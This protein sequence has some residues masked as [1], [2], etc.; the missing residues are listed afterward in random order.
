[1][2]LDDAINNRASVRSFKDK[3]VRWDLI[4]EAIDTASK[5]PFAGNINN[6][7]FIIVQNPDLKN[8]IAE[9]SQQDWIADAPIIAVLCS[10]DSKLEKMYYERGLVYSR[11]QAGAAIQNFLLKITDLGLESCWVGAYADELIKQL[12]KIPEYINIE[13]ILPVGYGRGKPK[14]IRKAHLENLINWDFWNVKKK[15]KK[16]KEPETW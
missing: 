2:K 12:L 9:H 1:M 11:Q 10:D 4:L 6:L 8:K 14:K 13:A 16:R 15:P 5:V 3:K 7:K